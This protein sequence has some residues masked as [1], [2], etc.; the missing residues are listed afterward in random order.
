MPVRD[1]EQLRAIWRGQAVTALQITPEQLRT[2]AAQFESAIRRR[3][4]RDQV[5][6]ALTAIICACGVLLHGV[7]LRV[8]SALT[9]IWALSSMYWLHR[10]GALAAA[11]MDSSAQTCAAYHQQQLERQRDIA[12][13]W[14]WGIGLALPG[15]VLVVVGLGVGAR[16]PNWE[17]SAVMI[18][19]FVF[20]YATLVIY[21]KMLAGQ[22]QREIDSLRSMREES[23]LS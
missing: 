2:R 11:P 23:Q 15:F 1:E 17:F 7:V 12:L 4:L 3:N 16:H 10:F 14:P 9:V 20:L 6:F 18:G 5:S 19:V 13:S 22:W 8:G 21:G